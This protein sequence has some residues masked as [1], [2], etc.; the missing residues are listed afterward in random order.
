MRLGVIAALATELGPTLRAFP[1]L[2]SPGPL[3]SGTRWSPPY[4]FRAGGVGAERAARAALLLADAARPDALVSAGFCGAVTGDLEVGDLVLGG[5]TRF[6]PSADLL[7]L[8]RVAWPRARSGRI[9]T[10]T[11]VLTDAA[12]KA[13]VARKS[14]AVA[15][16]MEADA[17]GRTAQ[18]RK[19]GFLCVKTVIDTPAEPLASAYAGIWTVLWEILS[20]PRTVAQMIYDSKRVTVGADRLRDFFLA[21]REKI[22]A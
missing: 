19:L 15:V 5:T 8:A 20:R 14:G 17:V 1:A 10:V 2:P 6:E 7:D 3:P 22:P 12:E 16:D 4:C 11:R 18:D 21:L 9:A 13:E